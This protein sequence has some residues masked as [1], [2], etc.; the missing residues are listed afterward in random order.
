MDGGNRLLPFQPRRRV[1]IFKRASAHANVLLKAATR[2]SA[3]PDVGVEQVHL[4]QSIQ[5]LED[6]KCLGK[7]RESFVGHPDAFLFLEISQEGVFQQPRDIT[8]VDSAWSRAGQE[9]YLWGQCRAVTEGSRG[10]NCKPEKSAIL[11]AS[12]KGP[13]RPPL[14]IDR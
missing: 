12:S 1:R 13:R 8:T 5:K 7:L 10:S 9:T 3:K 11:I 2:L 6:R 4:P 14:Q